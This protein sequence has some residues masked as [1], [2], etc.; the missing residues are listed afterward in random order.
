MVSQT[1]AVIIDRPLAYREKQELKLLANSGGVAMFTTDPAFLQ[2]LPLLESDEEVKRSINEKALQAVLDFGDR[3]FDGHSISQLLTIGG[4]TTW[5]YHKFRIYFRLRNLLY[6]T[7]TINKLSENYEE[8]TF[9]TGQNILGDS[10]L[11]PEK[12]TLVFS[13][14][15]RQKLFFSEMVKYAVFSCLRMLKGLGR[16]RKVKKRKILFV[17]SPRQYKHLVKGHS[18]E[19]VW[20]NSYLGPLYEKEGY[21]KETGIISQYLLPSFKQ[22]GEV[23]FSTGLTAA[24][25]PIPTLFSHAVYFV[26]YFKIYPFFA[27]RK[28]NKALKQAYRLM[29]KEKW[30]DPHEKIIFSL[31]KGLHGSTLFF[32]FK[33]V[34][35]REF[36]KSSNA[37][38]IVSIDEYSPN[39]KLILDA[40]K[41]NKI[42]TLAVQHGTLHR[43]HP[44]YRFTANDMR[45]QAFPDTFLAW[46]PSWKDFLVNT[47]NIPERRIGIIGQPRTDYLYEI[48][49]NNLNIRGDLTKGKGEIDQ[50]IMFASQPQRDEMLRKQAAADVFLAVKDLPGT[51][52]VLKMHP[53]ELDEAYYREIAKEMGCA[54]YIIEN[55]TDLYVLINSVDVVITCFSTVGTEALYFE[56]PV[57]ILDHLKQDLLGLCGAGVAVQASTATELKAVL[58]DIADGKLLIDK[59]TLNNYLSGIAY[60]I[61]GRVADRF[62][63]QVE[64]II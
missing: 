62:W 64:K 45:N 33:Y 61:D 53:R 29:E 30:P 17:E 51:M 48:R 43:L 39:Y 46:G 56:K 18:P 60:K 32:L 1:K 20:E 36:F 7:A 23:D 52:L 40:A 41:W 35:F 38:V 44:A 5:Y 12:V 11:L 37:R 25:H 28:L 10:G 26:Q 63:E 42:H 19:P 4:A 59:K 31:I 3:N 47:G 22:H 55:D 54:N 50:I 13:Q 58:Q 14:G 34:A 2:G 8:I 57:V 27:L 6:K 24:A 15:S 9:F 21:H 49:N 16:Y